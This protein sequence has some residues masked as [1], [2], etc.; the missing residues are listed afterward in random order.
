VS[1]DD[2]AAEFAAGVEKIKSDFR[3]LE[4]LRKPT[5]AA[6][7]GAALGGGLEGILQHD[8]GLP[9]DAGQNA[10]LVLPPRIHH[11][12]ATR[13]VHDGE[14]A[15]GSPAV[16]EIQ[17]LRRVPDPVARELERL[18][19]VSRELRMIEQVLED[20]G[21]RHEGLGVDVRADGGRFRHPHQ[22]GALLGGDLLGQRG[23]G[24]CCPGG[25]EARGEKQG[26]R[27]PGQGMMPQHRAPHYRR[28]HRR[29][30]TS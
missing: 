3:R 9:A 30:P 8:H 4:K 20:H 25:G 2:N 12:L 10:R 19:D 14:V 29:E 1:A 23:R 28:E 21:A 7:N 27:D 26:G 22:P 5:V 15:G 18:G 6:L 24:R 13:G 11:A 16:V 17:P